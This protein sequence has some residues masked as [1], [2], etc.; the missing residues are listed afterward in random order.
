MLYNAFIM[1]R[2]L[3]IKKEKVKYDFDKRSIPALVIFFVLA[4]IGIYMFFY[5]R[6]T[7]DFNKEKE[8]TIISATIFPVYDIIKNIVGSDEDFLVYL[9]ASKQSD[10]SN[11]SPDIVDDEIIKNSDV[12]YK[13]GVGY[14]DWLDNYVSQKKVK[15]VDLSTIIELEKSKRENTFEEYRDLCETNGGKW[16]SDYLEC[17]G[18]SKEE[19]LVNGGSFNNCASACRYNP[20][21]MCV[22]VCIPVCSFKNLSILDVSSDNLNE[23]NPYYWLSIDN[24][25]KISENIY[26]E[27]KGLKLED[28]TNLDTNYN[29]YIKSLD[30]MK[31]TIEDKIYNWNLTEIYTL[32]IS[33]NYFSKDFNLSAI[34][35]SYILTQDYSE[36]NANELEKII[37]KYK[38]KT[39]LI[40]NTESS[41]VLDDLESKNK[42]KVCELDSL[43]RNEETV[44][45]IDV[46]TKIA[47]VLTEGCN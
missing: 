7:R 8:K 42:I 27:L 40:D 14:D 30:E 2:N 33:Y 29:Q 13:I 15:V 6:S 19:C 43:G 32:G 41:A 4:V 36:A 20:S 5:W 3:K 39:I 25:K 44:S 38:I 22:Q 24:A 23:Y 16:L 31:K 47:G 26:Y 21:V 11:Y 17:E 12:I 18:L 28:S 10:P 35:L 9:I 1:I 45:Y 46:I 37:D 34:N